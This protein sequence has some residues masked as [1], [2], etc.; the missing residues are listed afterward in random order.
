MN[1]KS[2]IIIAIVV[3]I[4]LIA[5]FLI[6]DIGRKQPESYLSIINFEECAQAGYPILESYPP[7][8]KTPDGRTFTQA[9]ASTTSPTPSVTPSQT[10]TPTQSASASSTNV[11][12]ISPKAGST[13][14]SPVTITG[15]AKTW[16]FEASFP[17]KITDANGKVLGQGPAQAQGDWQTTAFVPFKAVISFASSTTKTG[18]IVLMK[19]NPSGDPARDESVSVQINFK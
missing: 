13:I 14:A 9:V 7:Q 18:F 17:I 3:I 8:C 12:N 1:R 10:P 2:L 5:L 16:Y 4:I 6:F 11:K 15:S 19:D